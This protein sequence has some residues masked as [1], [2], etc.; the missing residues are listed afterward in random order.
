MDPTL[1]FSNL[2]EDDLGAEALARI[3]SR[4]QKSRGEYGVLELFEVV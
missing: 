4:R 3:D 1:L 2:G